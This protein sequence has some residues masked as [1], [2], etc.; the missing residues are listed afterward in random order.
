[1]TDRRGPD[2]RLDAVRAAVA[3]GRR[4]TALRLLTQADPAWRRDPE[5][6]ARLSDSASPAEVVPLALQ[7]A[8]RGHHL[9]A[10]EVL[11]RTDL[12]DVPV[13]Q[14]RRV[15]RVL[16]HAGRHARSIE[17][18]SELT[19]REPDSD[20]YT[21]EMRALDTRALEL[22][23]MHL[24]A[25]DFLRRDEEAPARPVDG[26]VVIFN[27][28]HPVLTGLMVPLV[29]PLRARGF[30]VAALTVG[31]LA[32]PACGVELFDRLQGC[33][34]PDGQRFV[35][36]P[37]GPLS[38]DWAVDWEAGLVEAGGINYYQYFQERLAQ[39][40]R[41]YRVGLDEDPESA[42]RFAEL[43][44]QADVALSICERLLELARVHRKPV[45][46][47]L[48]DSHFAPQGVVREWCDRVGRHHG[49]HAVVMSVG[50]ENYYSNLGSLEA[51]T[52]AVEDL[53]AQPGLRQPFLG[54]PHRTEIALADDPS[55]ADEPDDLV[56]SW[57][58]QDRSKVSTSS[59]ERDLVADRVADARQRGGKVFG[60]LG[61]VTIDFAAPGDRG[62]AHEDFVEWINHLVTGVQGTDN[63]LLIKPHP[64]E[65]RREIVVEGVQLLRD[66]VPPQL[67]E[68]VVFLEH[69]SFNTH[70]LSQLLDAAFLWNGTASLEFSV[71]GVPVVPASIWAE[72][73]YP[74][75][76]EVLRSR[77]EYEQVLRGAREL[78]LVDG[79]ERRSALQ[80]RLMRSD[81]VALPFGYLRR[82]ATNLSVGAPRLDPARL[83]RLET[84]PDPYVER[85]CD[86]FFE[87]ASLPRE[88]RPGI[89]PSD[90]HLIPTVPA[91]P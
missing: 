71:L 59:P 85:A 63:L 66:L 46:V 91:S 41:R 34:A 38:H 84:A 26:F 67:P 23:T 64:H 57:I 27:V 2:R 43:L 7:L 77:A 39:K 35:E 73:D 24:V 56:M 31:T 10:S 37:R 11:V 90:G 60:A 29:A 88:A 15:A 12:G 68:N 81:H 51:T 14:R 62:F 42:E 13:G 17:L 9:L 32:T 44:A 40:A 48:M 3:E 18:L 4:R 21:E 83:A 89:G 25:N 36:Q 8:R 53:T 33:V 78:R 65:L 76:L 74:V 16:S 61:K 28:R 54:G 79:V 52:L 69:G 75:G 82:A 58:C 6:W 72:R 50:Y 87:F 19:A 49:V 5:I 70:E 45:R 22:A 20:L 80:L 86:R 30:P 47:A 1:L 55:L